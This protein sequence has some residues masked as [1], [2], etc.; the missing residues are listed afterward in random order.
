MAHALLSHPL[1][2]IKDELLPN[3]ERVALSYKRA[4]LV[5]LSFRALAPVHWLA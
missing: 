5:L 4:K 1:F 3:D 2:Q